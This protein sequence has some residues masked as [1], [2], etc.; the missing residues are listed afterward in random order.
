MT[1][2]RLF[3]KKAAHNEQHDIS[4]SEMLEITTRAID[5]CVAQATDLLPLIEFD[6]QLLPFYSA[7]NFF[8][9]SRWPNISA[10]ITP[11]II[12]DVAQLHTDRP[13]RMM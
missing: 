4:R 6:L 5:V 2:V 11:A 13:H 7:M 10:E 8:F 1:R 9:L 12:I 3:N